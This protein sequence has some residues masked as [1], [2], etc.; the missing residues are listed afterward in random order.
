ML[1]QDLCDPRRNYDERPRQRRGKSQKFH[2]RDRYRERS[3][4]VVQRGEIVFQRLR[5]VFLGV[6]S[7]VRYRGAPVAHRAKMVFV[8]IRGETLSHVRVLSHRRDSRRTDDSA[9][10]FISGAGERRN[11]NA[12]TAAVE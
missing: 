10:E 8:V 1:C 5:C 12:N 9:S 3:E 6:I 4:S 7:R 2:F 11:A